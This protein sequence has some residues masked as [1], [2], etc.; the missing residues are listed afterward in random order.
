[1]LG[2]V[3]SAAPGLQ[4]LRAGSLFP[5]LP[6]AMMLASVVMFLS[7]NLT[8][9]TDSPEKN[10]QTHTQRVVNQVGKGLG[11]HLRPLHGLLRAHSPQVCDITLRG[12]LGGE[13]R[14]RGRQTTCLLSVHLLRVVRKSLTLMLVSVPY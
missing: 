3:G 9:T 10:L 11:E 12:L 7:R 6:A 2:A 5:F 13:E 14:G 1:M 4:P 8:R